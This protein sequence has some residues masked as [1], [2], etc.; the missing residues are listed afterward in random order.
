[1][2]FGLSNELPAAENGN[3]LNKDIFWKIS[4]VK[5]HQ[6]CLYDPLLLLHYFLLATCEQIVNVT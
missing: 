6:R 2:C 4:V 3:F 1:M 5:I